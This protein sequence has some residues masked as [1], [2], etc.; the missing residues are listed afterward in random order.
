M[1]QMVS[2]N[3]SLGDPSNYSNRSSNLDSVTHPSTMAAMQ[4]AAV[5]AAAAATAA[6]LVLSNSRVRASL[7][8]D[9]TN[10]TYSSVLNSL[11][12]IPAYVSSPSPPQLPVLPNQPVGQNQP[13][14]IQDM[15]EH[16]HRQGAS[17]NSQTSQSY[18]HSQLFKTNHPISLPGIIHRQNNVIDTSED[19]LTNQ[20]IHTANYSNLPI[21]SMN[22]TSDIKPL[23][24]TNNT[25]SDIDNNWL[26]GAA[27][28]SMVARLKKGLISVRFSNMIN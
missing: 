7:A 20:S 17:I 2:A 15:S 4:A 1:A 8:E 10:L 21:A 11:S 14:Q 9:Y 5:A 27:P 28:D 26:N 12:D 25:G 23:I 19:H 13:V 18:G 22:S 6:G 16:H 3:Q 24:S